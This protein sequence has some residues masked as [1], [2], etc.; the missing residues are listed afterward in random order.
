MPEIEIEQVNDMDGDEALWMQTPGHDVDPDAFVQAVADWC[1]SCG[2]T[3]VGRVEDVQRRYLRTEPSTN[4]DYDEHYTLEDAPG[5]GLVPV[6]VID[7]DALDEGSRCERCERWIAEDDGHYVE[8][9][10]IGVNGKPDEMW[11]CDACAAKE[12]CADA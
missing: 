1:D 12:E 2:W 10:A 3:G 9:E 8:T 7:A 11:L 4:P 6:T 5:D